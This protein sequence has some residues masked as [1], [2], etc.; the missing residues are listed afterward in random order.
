MKANHRRCHLWLSTQDMKVR[1]AYLCQS[2]S[3]QEIK[4]TSTVTSDIEHEVLI[5]NRNNNSQISIET[6][7]PHQAGGFILKHYFG[8]SKCYREQVKKGF[9]LAHQQTT[10]VQS[11]FTV[12]RYAFLIDFPITINKPEILNQILLEGLETIK[13]LC[14]I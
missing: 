2:K 13:K 3:K 9:L 11:C 10:C 12:L 5:L 14:S 1:Q 7:V 4:C 8:V 6:S